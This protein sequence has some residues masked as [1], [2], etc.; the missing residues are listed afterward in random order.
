M[1]AAAGLAGSFW[2]NSC[3]NTA[4]VATPGCWYAAA[5]ICVVGGI[6]TALTAA[7]G[8]NLGNAKRDNAVGGVYRHGYLGKYHLDEH[9]KTIIL[10]Q[11]NDALLSIPGVSDV[12]SFHIADLDARSFGDKRDVTVDDT[13]ANA[14]VIIW[15]SIHGNHA[16]LYTSGV[17]NITDFAHYI[18]HSQ[19]VPANTETTD[20]YHNS[21]SVV[22]KRVRRGQNYF[23]V[24]YVGIGITPTTT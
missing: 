8:A 13:T 16:A 19:P 21:T 11:V 22:N 4:A 14:N 23:D 18:R 9:L 12:R 20:R 7:A 1:V 15:T 17:K 3:A 10:N 5:G 2:V 6:G 24:N